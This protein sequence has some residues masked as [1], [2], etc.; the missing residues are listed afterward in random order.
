[1]SLIVKIVSFDFSSDCS[2]Q[3]NLLDPWKEKSF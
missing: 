1:M 3:K 2:W